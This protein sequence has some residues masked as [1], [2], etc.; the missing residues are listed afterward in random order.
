LTFDYERARWSW[1]LE[2]VRAKASTENVLDL[3]VGKLHRLPPDTRSALQQLACLG[4]AADLTVLSMVLGTSAAQVHTDL[5]EAVRLELVERLAASYTFVHDRVREAA[6]S[7]IPVE[8]RVETHLRIGRLLAARTPPEQ[9]EEA[10]FEIVNQLNRGA[11][12]ITTREEREQLAELNLI[13]GQRAKRST[14]YAEALTYLSAGAALLGEDRW[15][16]QHELAFTL[17]LCRAECEFL[18]GALTDAEERLTSLATRAVTTVESA[19]VTCLRVDLYVTLDR[20]DRAIAVGLEY[21]R[22]LG[23]EWPPHPTEDEARH[24]YERIWSQLGTR[25]IEELL[26][27]PLMSDPAALATLNVLTKLGPPALY[28][29]MNLFTLIV[30]RAVNLS[31][32]RGN[33]DGSCVHYTWLGRV[34][35]ARFGDHQAAYRFGQLGYDLVE[36]RGLKRF[37][38]ETYLLFGHIVMPWTRHVRDGRDLL[39]RAFET[40]NQVGDL[41][42]AAYSCNMMITNL[43]AA[44]DPLVEVQREGEHGLAFAQKARFGLVIDIIATQLALVR[45]LRGL[46]PKF[47]CFDDAQF[48]ELR[49]ERRFSVNADLV[50]AE[51]WYW[52]R[53]L[54]VRFL[55]GDHTAAIEAASRAQRLLWTSLSLFETAEYE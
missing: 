39:R 30:C 25:T 44:G 14:A 4:N 6:Y 17:E 37:Q 40:A 36:Q 31:L 51:S 54:Q 50:R 26:S 46:T 52:I 7:L 22:P 48:D 21:L 27:L 41:T 47:G 10:I 23:L 24:E 16:R 29:D 45:T 12:L 8:L 9:R 11:A 55:A 19:T 43:L 3:M 1:D 32:E 5:S 13:A 42:Y 2:R 28:T 34:I 49:I 18:T 53:K 20:S 38:A 33:C 15:E 35:G